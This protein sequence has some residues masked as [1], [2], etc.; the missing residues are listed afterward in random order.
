MDP[1]EKALEGLR[2]AAEA[3]AKVKTALDSLTTEER[4]AF[5]DAR[6]DEINELAEGFEGFFMPPQWEDG[7]QKGG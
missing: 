3:Y 1:K 5:L 4:L 2:E 6:E 7:C